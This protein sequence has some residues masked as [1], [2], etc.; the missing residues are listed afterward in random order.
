MDVG[1]RK[2]CVVQVT[3]PPTLNFFL[4]ILKLEG[5]KRKAE[6]NN[7]I[8][9][10]SYNFRICRKNTYQ[11]DHLKWKSKC[12]YIQSLV[13]EV[14]GLKQGYIFKNRPFYIIFVFLAHQSRRL[15]VSL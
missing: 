1:P 15:R 14:R 2:K 12:L 11:N 10:F 7:F 5:W 13:L 6:Q 8:L 3:R 4:Q 9:L